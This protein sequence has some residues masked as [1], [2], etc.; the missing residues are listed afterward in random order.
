MDGMNFPA[1]EAAVIGSLLIDP[2]RAMPELARQLQPEDFSSAPLRHLFEA[3]RELYLAKKP[4][5][6]V[7]IGAQAGDQKNY[8][9]LAQALMEATPSA[10]NVKEYAAI[11]RQEAQL[12]ALRSIGLAISTSADLA[13]ARELA[14]KAA[15]ISADRRAERGAQ[16]KDLAL[17]FVTALGDEPQPFLPLGID[18]L[19][20]AARVRPGQ[21]VILG[22]YNSVGKTALALQMAFA[23]AKAG[24]RV[25]FFSLET[26]NTLLAQRV[27]AQQTS[28]KMTD[29]Q[30]HSLTDAENRRLI[31]LG[32]DSWTYDLRFYSAAGWSPDTVRAH[33]LADRLEVAFIDYVQLL[34]APGD[35][36]ALQVRTISMALHTMAQ[37]LGVTVF[38]LSQV[39]LPE[40][41]PKTGKRPP[42]RKENLR[43]S[44]QLAND[45]DIVLLLDLVDPDDY[46][47]PRTLLMDKNKDVG[48]GFMTLT[49]MAPFL[50]FSA[51]PPNTVEENEKEASRKRVEAM[52]RTRERK[53]EKR[54]A[55]V[56]KRE[57]DDA[58][59]AAME[60][61]EA[62][63][64][65]PQ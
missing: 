10:A 17:A 62:K 42:L 61:G 34:A 37:S 30:D 23:L 6:A 53:N 13:Q 40:R 20:R 9:G 51:A 8:V 52:D 55:A 2:D 29:L 12:R 1:T 50:R 3:A 11:L 47:G 27:F 31:D 46:E 33:V 58:A 49:Y 24:H 65:L 44:Q 45:A 15:E 36:P 18:E 43:E 64:E 19:S 4:V 41:N 5:D 7:T 63:E 57:E 22:A 25:G 56:R 54:R 16:W 35:H 21:F 60:A 28:I 26:A 32:Q 38:G 14:E 59:F 39:T 48:R